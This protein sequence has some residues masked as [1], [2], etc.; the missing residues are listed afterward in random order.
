M[1]DSFKGVILMAGFIGQAL[2]ALFKEN[3]TLVASAKIV[4]G[5]AACNERYVEETRETYPD[6]QRVPCIKW[7]IEFATREDAEH[8]EKAVA[9]MLEHSIGE[10]E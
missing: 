8:F 10:G 6:G 5:L 2:G 4:A 1:S 7:S 9:A 3:E